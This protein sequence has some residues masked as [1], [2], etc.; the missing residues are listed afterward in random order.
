MFSIGKNINTFS[1]RYS[2]L[3]TEAQKR[4][5]KNI[6]EDTLPGAK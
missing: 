6:R 4:V 1:R 5:I 3:L 2:L